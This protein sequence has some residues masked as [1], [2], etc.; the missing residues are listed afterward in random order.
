MAH[1]TGTQLGWPHPQLGS[2]TKD[3]WSTVSCRDGVGE[4]ELG[5]LNH[6]GFKKHQET[7]RKHSFLLRGIP[8]FCG[9]R[10]KKHQDGKKQSMVGSYTQSFVLTSR[11]FPFLFGGGANPW[12]PEATLGGQWFSKYPG[13]FSQH[14]PCS[15]ISWSTNVYHHCYTPDPLRT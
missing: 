8:N 9:F 13:G 10:R 12:N 7:M 15:R 11:C 2:P 3:L 6:Q 14:F 4:S 5:R 1:F